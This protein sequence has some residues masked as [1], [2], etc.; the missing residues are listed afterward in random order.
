MAKERSGLKTVLI[1][2]YIPIFLTCFALM[3]WYVYYLMFL[4][5]DFFIS[6][7][8]LDEA[9][10]SDEEKYFI[11]I[12]YFNNEK[13]NGVEAFEV[14]LNFYTDA[15][16]PEQNEDGSY[17]TKTM[18]S[19]GFQ[20]IGGLSY[21]FNEDTSLD[22]V[23]TGHDEHYYKIKDGYYYDTEMGA[24]SFGSLRGEKITDRDKF[25]YDI[26]GEL[27]LVQ[28]Q[29]L[30]YT[31]NN[32]WVKQYTAHDVSYF[33][34]SIYETVKSLDSGE[35]IFVID[36]SDDFFVTLQNENGSF[37]TENH[38]SDE[39]FLFTNIKVNISDNGLISSEQSMFGIVM[40]DADW[41]LDN[42]G[43]EEYWQ[44]KTTYYLDNEDLTVKY[45]DGGF[46]ATLK[47]SVVN[48]MS[49]FRNLNL[50]V[51]I[52]LD[53][54]VVNG[55]K[56]E[57]RGLAENAFADLEI[58][59]IN[60]TSIQQRDFYVYDTSNINSDGNINLVLIESEEVVA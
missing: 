41:T 50:I 38:T 45:E 47:T 48:Y 10:Y 44:T 52:D 23:F 51:N 54:F 3:L 1:L 17:D 40:N 46:Y 18:Y 9:T 27:C 43:R 58:S 20:S 36:L 59:E 53:N 8:Y 6:T 24:T 15:H 37:D 26:N 56:I 22:A 55:Q 39:Q 29:G 11:E 30:T 4:S 60:L 35:Q 32:A 25:I 13:G 49:P 5:D 28:T 7:A 14:K 19:S 12:N 33:L 2:C 16:L 42:T 31:H 34:T 21:S 57:L